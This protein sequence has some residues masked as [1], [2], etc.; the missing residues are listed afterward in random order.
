MLLMKRLIRTSRKIKILEFIH[1]NG[2]IHN[3]LKN[4]RIPE[5]GEEVDL[6]GYFDAWSTHPIVRTH[7]ETKRRLFM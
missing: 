7:P 4:N 6:A 5:R 1:A 2:R 3:T